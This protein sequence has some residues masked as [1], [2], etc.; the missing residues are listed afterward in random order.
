MTTAPRTSTTWIVSWVASF[1][2]FWLWRGG[3]LAD[4]AASTRCR[5]A[6]GGRTAWCSIF[7]NGWRNKSDC[8]GRV[9]V[10]ERRGARFFATASPRTP[11]PSMERPV[12]QCVERP[13]PSMDECVERPVGQNIL[14][15]H[16]NTSPP[17]LG[18][19][20]VVM[21]WFCRTRRRYEELSM[22][23][24][25]WRRCSSVLRGVGPPSFRGVD[26]FE[27]KKF[28]C[29][30]QKLES[31]FSQS[32][33]T[34]LQD[35]CSIV[36]KKF[37]RGATDKEPLE[38]TLFCRPLPSNPVRA[39][40]VDQQ[41]WLGRDLMAEDDYGSGARNKNL[42]RRDFHRVPVRTRASP[43]RV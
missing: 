39:N 33:F 4:A 38:T 32:S 41:R 29:A 16:A 1:E 26:E 14:Q 36:S 28:Q 8:G 34:I 30:Q 17:M 21:C 6:S 5:T 25:R 27:R 10:D 11:V 12:E 7:C 42:S 15:M 18:E 3:G 19:V 43:A 23:M 24:D 35:L 37:H 13:V 9:W 31:W 2:K 40:P 20:C 22:V